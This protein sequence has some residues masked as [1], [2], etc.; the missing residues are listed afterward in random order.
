MPSRAA[1]KPLRVRLFGEPSVLL[2]DGRAVVLE[3]RAAALVALAAFEPGFARE[4]A[5][6][7]LWPDST[8][9]RRNLRQQLL[10]FR[11]GIEAPLFADD[12]TLTLAAGVQLVKAQPG[13]EVIVG[14]DFT[15]CPEF[16]DWLTRRRQSERQRQ[17]VR[18]REQLSESQAQGDLNSAL[19]LAEALLACDS[20]SE[21]HH[22][23]LMRVHYLRGDAAAGLA[24][25]QRLVRRLADEHGAK[26]H[27]DTEA[28]ARALRDS[29]TP[30][31]TRFRAVPPTLLRPPRM[32]GRERELQAL[33][34]AWAS[35]TTTLV[36]GEPGLGKT[37]LLSEF[38]GGRAM[39][40]VQAR[41]GDAGVPYATLARL[42]R[43]LLTPDFAL[44]LPDVRRVALA[45]LLPELAP[46]LP[47]PLDG[48]RLVLRSAIETVLEQAAASGM[49]GI[50]V[51]DLHFADDASVEM[52]QTLIVAER[53]VP[54]RFVLAAR[55]GET[56]VAAQALRHALEES[57]LLHTLPVMPLDGVALEALVRSLGLPDLDPAVVA[58]LLLRHCG[59]NPLYALETLKQG[60][61][62]GS[63][64][65][66]RLVLPASV[67]VLLEQRLRKLSTDALTL[68]R[69]AAIA[70]VDFS[71]D[72]AETVTGTRAVALADAWA[73]LEAAQVLRDSAF[74][75]DLVCDAVLR[76]IPRPIARHLHGTTARW[77]EQHAGEPARVARH[78]MS[79]ENSEKALPAWMA[80]AE[81]AVGSMRHAEALLMYEEA[82]AI[83]AAANRAN[84]ETAV[85]FRMSESLR[86]LEDA[87][88]TQRV[89][90]RMLEIARDDLGRA[91][92]FLA[93]AR[94][95]FECRRVEEA[96][97]HGE[98]ALVHA[99]AANDAD[100]TGRI[101]SQ[102]AIMLAD[103]MR[104]DD[105]QAHLDAV[106]DWASGA[107][108]DQRFLYF[109]TT[110][111]IA[112]S[113]EDFSASIAAYERA[114]DQPADVIDSS[115]LAQTCGNI[116]V[117]Y[118]GM[119]AMRS[120]LA[121][122]E[123]RRAIVAQHEITGLSQAYLELNAA[124]I[125]MAVGRYREADSFL[126]KAEERG[127]PDTSMLYLRW[128]TLMF[129]LGQHARAL[130]HLDHVDA[131]PGGYPIIKLAARALRAQLR[132]AIGQP[133]TNAVEMLSTADELAV[134]DGR[135]AA[136][137]RALL[138]HAEFG[139]PDDAQD[140]A[141][142]AAALARERG[143]YGL[144]LA[145]Q[146]LLLEQTVAR[147]QAA[148]VVD[149]VRRV[150]VLR[151]T[152]ESHA[153][154]RARV[155]LAAYRVLA[156]AGDASALQVRARER[157][158]ITAT[159]ERDVPPSYRES[160]L[161]RNPVNRALL[162]GGGD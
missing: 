17:M 24:A 43:R 57:Q 109:F 21:A 42:L 9:P 67:G 38:C 132:R 76:T 19:S 154:Y 37:R 135:I 13:A 119:G 58:P 62:D 133:V 117:S 69:V 105:A 90:A 122:D 41:P 94:A 92:A 143:L 128:A 63:L 82:R 156:A 75:H 84:D 86:F 153:M 48:Q 34:A 159:A 55:P 98:Q 157:E 2:P 160:F 26:P 130:R 107:P 68:A 124:T 138:A 4:R 32:M 149:D 11:R 73:E 78:W 23:E 118:A 56:G 158:W 46:G 104:I 29:G 145:A 44:A 139:D 47:L 45:R 127:A 93:A 121:Y 3:R 99:N 125:L 116:A 115:D 108:P 83:H 140:Y 30:V 106:R 97:G 15:D 77:L 112:M 162:T 5:A 14:L 147:G 22:R 7:W 50:A 61:D 16:A 1:A 72:L 110:G 52:L 59:G 6:R 85:L 123:R 65:E 103:Q 20:D 134:A 100:V 102:L 87:P 12:E 54:L 137:V 142:R 146:T 91:R 151:E 95:A 89:L 129:F 111:W 79:A 40:A 8:D 126:A 27:A 155:G 81:R 10:R 51:D 114:L 80:A 161:Q 31:A 88:A 136:R 66:G 25:H 96:I 39:L 36:L 113:R 144:Q 53:A 148:S 131:V 64:L 28:L 49:A 150:I 101:R 70:G 35:G 60:W 33:E 18:L 74:A 141:R 71:T 152:Y 120:A